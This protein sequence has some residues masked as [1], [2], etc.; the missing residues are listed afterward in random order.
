ML[1]NR[2]YCIDTPLFKG[3]AQIP[4]RPHILVVPNSVVGQWHLELKRFFFRHAIDIFEIPS[5]VENAENFFI[6]GPWV[7]ST[8]E[9][10]RKVVI[11]SHTVRCSPAYTIL[12]LNYFSRGWLHTRIIASTFFGLGA[13]DL[14]TSRMS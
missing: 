2:L 9:D 13:V 7:E 1:T 3:E 10:I 11:C 6:E 12:C 8:H 5:N 4:N 14:W